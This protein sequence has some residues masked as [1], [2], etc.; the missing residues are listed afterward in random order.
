VDMMF[1]NGNM[2]NEK[3]DMEILKRF[4]EEEKLEEEK[5]IHLQGSE[6]VPRNGIRNSME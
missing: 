3:F 1:L 6:L 2:Q 5:V 4:I